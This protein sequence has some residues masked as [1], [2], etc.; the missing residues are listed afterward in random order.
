MK[1]IRSVLTWGSRGQ[2]FFRNTPREN[3]THYKPCDMGTHRED[4]GHD[5][6]AFH[7]AVN[8]QEFRMNSCVTGKDTVD[9]ECSRLLFHRMINTKK[10]AK[11][12]CHGNWYC[13]RKLWTNT[14]TCSSRVVQAAQLICF[15]SDIPRCTRRIGGEQSFGTSMLRIFSQK[16]GLGNLS[17]EAP[18]G[19]YGKKSRAI[20]RQT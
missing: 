11:P 13:A 7:N 4:R 2:I 1:N 9:C 18:M 6:V 12:A 16:N 10:P 5:N 20:F 3:K 8:T 17:R 19:F 15:P 14:R